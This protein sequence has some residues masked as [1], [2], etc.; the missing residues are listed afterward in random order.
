MDE[1][2][3][4]KASQFPSTSKARTMVERNGEGGGDAFGVEF[5]WVGVRSWLFGEYEHVREPFLPTL[6][7]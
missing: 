3:A 6:E 5:E 1:R 2:S 7:G 4:G